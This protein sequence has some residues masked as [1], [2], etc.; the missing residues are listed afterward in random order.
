MRVV[1]KPLNHSTCARVEIYIKFFFCM[2]KTGDRP[3]P[4]SISHCSF[5]HRVL[6]LLQLR[7]K[8]VDF[9]LQCHMT[10]CATMPKY[11][12]FLLLTIKYHH[13]TQ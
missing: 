11:L 7:E 6:V 12:L 2:S 1:A 3:F 13:I 9:Y 5:M 10:N 8:L 4:H